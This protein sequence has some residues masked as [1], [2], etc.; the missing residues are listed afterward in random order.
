MPA[1]L[2][3][4]E[5]QLLPASLTTL[6][7]VSVDA[8]LGMLLHDPNEPLDAL[9]YLTREDR[10]GTTRMID[11][12]TI[13][14]RLTE[15]KLGLN[16]AS[17]L[18]FAGLPSTLTRLS[19]VNMDVRTLPLLPR[20]LTDLNCNVMVQDAQAKMGEA[21][22]VEYVRQAPPNLT[23]LKSLSVLEFKSSVIAAIPRTVTLGELGISSKNRSTAPWSY[24]LSQALPPGISSYKVHTIDSFI[25]TE[26]TW[27]ESLPKQLTRLVLGKSVA[28]VLLTLDL[29][30]VLPPLLTELNGHYQIRWDSV[31]TDETSE[32]GPTLLWPPHLKRMEQLASCQHFGILEIMPR[33]LRQL[34]LKEDIR[35][36]HETTHLPPLLESLEIQTRPVHSQIFSFRYTFPDTL[37]SLK[38]H[39]L[40]SSGKSMGV[41]I[42]TLDL[43]PRRMRLIYLQLDRNPLKKK[44]LE[45]ISSFKVLEELVVDCWR[46]DWFDFLPKSLITFKASEILPSESTPARR[47][48]IIYKKE[49]MFAQLPPYL[50]NLELGDKGK[51]CYKALSATSFASLH[52]LTNLSVHQMAT[53]ESGVLRSLPRMLTRLYI[54]LDSLNTEDLPFLP[55]HL[56]TISLGN[57]IIP[58][59]E[60]NFQHL[61]PVPCLSRIHDQNSKPELYAR[62]TLYPDPRAI[63]DFK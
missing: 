30:K 23:H 5:L 2:L 19:A 44:H 49:D 39:T 13:L 41:D 54:S 17:F 45:T 22:C 24:A 60:A 42:S 4:R 53:F 58:L 9:Q 62:A 34:Y 1:A 48:E 51:E 56:A 7:L 52:H 18:D 20:G 15:L 6:K 47:P 38:V 32:R 28:P 40:E 36:L 63:I 35:D 26:M 10:L 50:T 25:S 33:T 16:G 57:N 46:Q 3:S 43:L 59:E 21:I 31:L 14:P 37:T 27:P 12:S 29:L 8:K 55:P 11:M 61:L